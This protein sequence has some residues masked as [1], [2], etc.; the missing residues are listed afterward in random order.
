MMR[1]SRCRCGGFTLVEL[2]VVVA[3]IAFVTAAAVPTLSLTV[4]QNRQRDAGVLIVQA[5]FTARS[6][7]ARNDLCH[8]VRVYTDP[9]LTTGSGGAVAIEQCDNRDCG[10]A[11]MQCTTLSFKSV[12]GGTD[13][14]GGA[15]HVRLVGDDI[16]ID[17]VLQDNLGLPGAD[18]GGAPAGFMCFDPMGGLYLQVSQNCG[19]GVARFFRVRAFQAP[20]V[21]AGTRQGFVRVSTGGGVRYTF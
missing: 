9:N 13:P 5:V 14:I 21:P 19:P 16:A 11:G 12:G 8:R 20:N 7:A 4:K 6:L 18:M 1:V 10:A 17:S 2:M 3:V 15:A